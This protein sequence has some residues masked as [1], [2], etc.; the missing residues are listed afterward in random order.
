MKR[1]GK[2]RQIRV[3]VIGYGGAFDMGRHHLLEMMR[4]KMTP[5]AVADIDPARLEIARGD[6]PGIETYTSV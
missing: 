6:F 2:A 5:A 4:A 3:G 1:F